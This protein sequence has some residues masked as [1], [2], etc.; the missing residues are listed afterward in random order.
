VKQ[1]RMEAGMSLGQVANGVV[2]RTAI[3]FVETGKAKPSIET[4]R[5]IAERT[6]RPLDFFLAQ[7]STLE[8]RSSPR[9][10][11][12]ELLLA[13]NDPAAA[14]AS[15]RELLAAERDP[16]TIA[17]AK[18]LVAY[19]LLRLAQPIEA[20]SLA[21]DA[22]E[23]FEKVGDRLMTAE[24]LGHEASA[25]YLL[26][27][28]R[29][30]GLAERGLEICRSLQPVSRTTEARLLFVL[31]SV[32][33]VNQ[34]WQ[35]AVDCYERAIAA[36]SIVQDLRR[37]SMMYGGLSIAYGEIGQLNQSAYYAHRAL[38]IHETLNDRLSLARSENN[39]GMVLIKRGDL[40]GAD[41]HL[42]RALALF[43]E[44]GVEVGKAIVLLSLCELSVARSLLDAAERYAVEAL[45]GAERLAE[46][47]TQA[48][49]HMWLG[50]IAAE[51]GDDARVDSEFREAWGI[52]DALGAPERLSRCH[53]TYAEILE[54]RGDI[55]GANHQLRLAL[56]Q[57]HPGKIAPV[58][59]E[60]STATA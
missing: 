17:R 37:L 1:A 43:G 58:A 9:T 54:R 59:R 48:D 46:K 23:Y 30:L 31:G 45:D 15:G 21:A 11:E 12:L 55:A 2:S 16:D 51:R 22:R 57:L 8:P 14:V 26:E 56:S 25:A 20:R 39:L 41:E 50:R 49:S 33:I 35:A 18:H 10:L 32:H 60:A 34:D 6:G 5:L 44:L 27:D 36:G 29:A 13:T 40:A 4:L 28:P 7:P 24:C 52:L 53:V 38:T 19:A 47:A 3:Y 42:N